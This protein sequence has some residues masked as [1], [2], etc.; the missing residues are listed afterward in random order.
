[1]PIKRE[2]LKRYPADWKAISARIR[3]RDG[4]RC[5]WCG[6][7]NGALGYREADGTFVETPGLQAEAARLDGHK[8]IRIVLTVA[9]VHDHA[10]ENCEPD[11]LAALCQRC[12][13]RHDLPNRR[14]NAAATLRKRRA[15]NQLELPEVLR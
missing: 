4:N 14:R 12:H 1:M 3:E 15:W 8:V 5:K 10:P 2:N 13:N 6:V 9:H 11:N 7:E